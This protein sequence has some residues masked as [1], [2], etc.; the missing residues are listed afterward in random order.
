MKEINQQQ[1]KQDQSQATGLEIQSSNLRREENEQ[2]NSKEPSKTEKSD[3]AGILKTNKIEN[4]TYSK[5]NNILHTA[6]LKNELERTILEIEICNEYK[7]LI[8]TE[9]DI[10]LNSSNKNNHEKN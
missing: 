7:A 9:H 1:S 8:N 2:S 5:A 10:P 6:N 3:A 4:L